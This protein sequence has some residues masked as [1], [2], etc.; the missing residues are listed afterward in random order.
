MLRHCKIELKAFHCRIV[1]DHTALK[2]EEASYKEIPVI[3]NIDASMV[4][5]NYLQIKRDVQDI[6]Q[7]ELAALINDPSLSHLLV[8]K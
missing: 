4:E 1:N 3:R 8:R 2:K 6:I 5:Q 7:S